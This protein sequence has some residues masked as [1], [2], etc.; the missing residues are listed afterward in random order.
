MHEKL[1]L[2][3]DWHNRGSAVTL[4]GVGGQETGT[5]GSTPERQL[6]P[7]VVWVGVIAAAQ[8]A[9]IARVVT[10]GT[11]LASSRWSA[12]CARRGCRLMHLP[13][14]SA[15]RWCRRIFYVRRRYLRK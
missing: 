10:V 4:T 9:G 15:R 6:G 8:A 13:C 12:E 7:L 3:A 5:V 2:G 11:D 14:G 1:S